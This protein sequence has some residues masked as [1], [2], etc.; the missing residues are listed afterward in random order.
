MEA[1]HINVPDKKGTVHN[2][3]SLLI[4]N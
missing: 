4:T 3:G 2:V 1:I